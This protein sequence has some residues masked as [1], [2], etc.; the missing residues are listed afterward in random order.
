MLCRSSDLTLVKV[1]SSALGSSRSVSMKGRIQRTHGATLSHD[2]P[3]GTRWVF[4]KQRVPRN[5]LKS[6]NWL[7][8][9][10]D[11]LHQH[12]MKTA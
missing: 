12:F 6:F 1:L 2:R 9:V 4:V 11:H 7:S 5:G 10:V 3:A 8:D